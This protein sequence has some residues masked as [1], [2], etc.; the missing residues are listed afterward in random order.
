MQ[1]LFLTVGLSAILATPAFAGDPVHG[2]ELY[3][4]RCIACHSPDANRVGPM[5]RGVVGRLSG[6]VPGFNYSK[7]LKGAQVTWDEQSLD[8]WLANPR[9]SSP[10][11]R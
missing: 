4:S 11:R 6:T 1:K 8:Q 7:A 5:H 9:P 3:E 2:Q 10:A